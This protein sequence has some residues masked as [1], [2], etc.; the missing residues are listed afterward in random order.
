MDSSAPPQPPAALRT[1][2]LA[3][4]SLV[5]GILS[6]GLWILAGLPAVICGHVS[7][8]QIKKAAG[9]IGGRGLAIAG[10]ITGYLGI[11]GTVVIV[12][13]SAAIYKMGP[14]LDI[15][16]GV[17]TRADIQTM[18]T[19]LLSYSAINGFYP[20]TEQGLKALVV[21]PETEPA[22][23]SWRRSMDAV[24][25]DPWGS[26][27]VYRNPGVKNPSSYDLFSA[28]PDRKPDTA[29]DDWGE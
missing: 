3:I 13:F 11:V 17:K 1:S 24:P 27:Y 8:S 6:F 14:T 28:G 18:R 16:K 5:L 22:P 9:T 21:R 4:A 23:P 15:A 2:G 20:T 29:D 10:L 19:M 26:E 12:L 7:L 25:K